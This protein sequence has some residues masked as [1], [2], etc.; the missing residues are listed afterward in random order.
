M[1]RDIYTNIVS[2][3]LRLLML[4]VVKTLRIKKTGFD[5]VEGN[6]IYAVWHQ[7]IFIFGPANPLKKTLIITA[8]GVKGD[9][10]TKA[11]ERYTDK[12]LRVPFFE[13]NP[14][15]AA[16]AAVQGIRLLDEGFNL[17]VTLDG[18]RGPIFSVKPGIFH[19][20]RMSNKRIIPIV[21]ACSMKITLP[22]RWDKYFIPV[23]FSRVVM[24]AYPDFVN[25]GNAMSLKK[26]MFEA[27]RKAEDLLRR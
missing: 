14:R 22:L 7:S 9:I 19:F 12:V 15:K 17:V 16:A 5:K 21:V 18:P 2:T 13:D 20:A 24:L 23:P 4:G 3:A 1:I 10:F 11:V 27:A 6:A 26:T 25:D 8:D